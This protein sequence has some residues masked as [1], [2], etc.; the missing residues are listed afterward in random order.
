MKN[1]LSK[2]LSFTDQEYDLFISKS[3][4]LEFNKSEFLMTP[5]EVTKKIFFINEG[6]VRGYRLVD[7]K[8]IT[9]FFYRNNWFATDYES[10]LENTRGDLYLQALVNTSVYVFHK[11]TLYQFFKEV[12]K[13]EK[14]RYIIAEYSYLHMVRRYKN[15]QVNDLRAK[16]IN[17]ITEYPELF[18]LVPQKYIASYLGVEPQS[19]SR[20][21][22]S[23]DRKRS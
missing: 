20:I 19:L 6:F 13:F 18:H 17:A 11:S 3:E 22:K 8:E 5:N 10:F 4:Q 23:T 12:T 21:K 2:H 9:H 7:G 14:I 1:I 16:Y 15:L